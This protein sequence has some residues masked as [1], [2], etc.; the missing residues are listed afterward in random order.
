MKKLILITI[1]VLTL[2][3]AGYSQKNAK[4]CDIKGYVFD[5]DANGLNVRATPD[6]N[7]RVLSRLKKGAGDI[8]VDIIGS[9]GTGWVKITNAWH[10]EDGEL[11][12]DKGWVFASLLAT[13]TKGSPNY[14]SSVK[15]YSAP[16]K[17]SKALKEI[18]S[19]EEV[20]VLDCTGT[21]AKVK[22][23][24]TIGWLARENQCGSPFTTCN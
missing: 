22:Y 14:D 16:S 18:R 7:G 10:G 15:L 23:F 6:K 19:E 21:W 5:D 2:F 3:S 11:F 20:I 13:G 8:S 12:N 1:A 17:N 4:S 9:S 24:K